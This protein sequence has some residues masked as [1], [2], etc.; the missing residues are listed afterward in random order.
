[1]DVPKILG[2]L[3]LPEKAAL[4]A[5]TDFMYTN[6]VPRLGIPSIR[7]S[8]GPHGL[9]VQIG[10]G[11]NGVAESEPATSFP[12]AAA[13]SCSFDA[14]LLYE[15]GQAMGK[16]AR[17]YGVSIL[18]GPGANLKR[19][20]LAGRNFEYFSE[21]PLLSGKL[22]AALIEGIQSQG[23]GACLKHYALNNAE[24]H[25][26]YGE[27]V[28]SD[29]A[30]RELYLKSFE[31]AVKEGHPACVM[32]AYNKVDGLYCGENPF[33]LKTL[34]RDEWGFD[35]LV[36][37]DWGGT[38]DRKK[39]LEAGCDLEMPGDTAVC[40]A[41]ILEGIEDKSLSQEALD[42]A[43]RN[44]LRTVDRFEPTISPS[45]EFEDHDPLALKIALSSAVLL[46]NDGILPL[47]KEEPLIVLGDLFAK[48]RYQGSGSSMIHPR[49][50]VTPKDAFDEAKAPYLYARGYSSS[51]EEADPSLEEEAKRLLKGN[52]KTCLLFLG[53]TDLTESEG[54]DR[55]SLALPA[56]QVSL[57]RLALASNKKV[58]IV[59]FGGSP[60]AMPDLLEASAIL[61]MRLPG[62]QGGKAAYQLLFGE[63]SPSGRLSET[64][65]LRYE[66][67][68]Y[69]QEF[70]K[71]PIEVYKEDVYVG[72]R[73]YGS[74]G[75]DVAFPF[76][77]GLSYA[78]F[79]YRDFLAD[80]DEE[81]I[82]F[83]VKVK[84]EGDMQAS[85]VVELYVSPPG[86]QVHRPFMELKGFAKV[87][88]A[89]HEEK[90]I[91][92][93]IKT[94]DLRY[95]SEKTKRF[96]LEP[97][98]Y[99]FYLGK[100]CLSPILAL[101]I[102]LQGE[103]IQEDQFAN[104][105]YGRDP[106]SLSDEDFERASGKKIPKAPP[107]FPITMES[108]FQDLASSKFL[109]RILY[110]AVL[111]VAH[112]Q[113]KKGERMEEGARKDNVLKGAK[114]LE[115]ILDSNSLTTMSM[116]AGR[117]CPYHFALGFREFANG[118]PFKGIASFL[119]PIKAPKL[120]KEEKE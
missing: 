103:A 44:V 9:R 64:I 83:R 89:P 24:N 15:M 10:S 72:Y 20:P 110:K 17:H 67:V 100:D 39:M 112:K 23:V 99:R 113:R 36:M 76:G 51:K 26:F 40:R 79:S 50:L 13:S 74:Y 21:D 28:A 16:E 66:D 105:V 30:M 77:H 7:M 3:T 75:K 90:E 55:E 97:G 65:P 49:N 88:L 34:L 19:N 56:N 71:S 69:G 22:A 93:K 18:L 61:D 29:R 84:N 92:L 120:P 118:H 46:Q 59:L 60:V 106:T 78:K 95:Y 12:T 62:E 96:V 14:E 33:L 31:I 47:K 82:L 80:G 6:P 32:N 35:G 109:G 108:R 48:M 53:L 58:V 114:F 85:E 115:R 37:T 87:H 4:V 38:H 52:E 54:A 101:D 107:R 43:V 41:W 57:L 45:P 117:S 111:S 91:S 73:Y 116:S 8:D 119:R 2:S 81:E 94:E 70:S 11:D 104:E 102:D 68:P 27:S 25:R 86:K 1:M 5:G 42:A 63:V 98:P